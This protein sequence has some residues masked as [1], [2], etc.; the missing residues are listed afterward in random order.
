MDNST[1]EV[2]ESERIIAE[3]REEIKGYEHKIETIGDIEYYR[4]MIALRNNIIGAAKERIEVTRQ[5]MRD[6]GVVKFSI[7]GVNKRIG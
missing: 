2:K 5:V 4:E 7:H 6:L 1:E 3:K